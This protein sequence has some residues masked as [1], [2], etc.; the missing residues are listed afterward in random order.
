M[1]IDLKQEALMLLGF[2]ALMK[3]S[4]HPITPPYGAKRRN[5]H[6]EIWGGGESRV[7]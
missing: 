4:A 1:E 5:F 2:P 3:L 7:K 6:Q